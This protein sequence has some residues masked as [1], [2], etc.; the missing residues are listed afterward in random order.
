[1]RKVTHLISCAL[2]ACFL[3]APT[4]AGHAVA[5]AILPTS[6]APLA[7]S[8]YD[9]ASYG[10]SETAEKQAAA[11]WQGWQTG[12]LTAPL[13]SLQLT[14]FVKH[15]I[16][17]T[18]AAR[19]LALMHV[20]MHD[21]WLVK[22]DEVSRQLAVASAASQVLGYLF[23]SEEHDFERTLAALIKRSGSTSLAG[24]QVGRQIGQQAIARAEGDGAARGWNGLRLEWYGEGRYFGPGSW[25]PTP[26]YFYYPP[27]EPF[28]PSWRTW[29]VQDIAQLRTTAPAFGSEKFVRDLQEVL[30]VQK[31]LTPE[32]LRIAQFWVDGSGTVTPPGHWN[33]I[34]LDLA[35]EHRLSEADTVRLFASLN[36]A[37]ADTF[38]T[39]WDIKYHY[40]SARPVTMAKTVLGVEFTPA[41]LTPPFPSYVSG[42]AAFSGAA[43]KVIGAYI[44]A[45]AKKVE[46]MAEEAAM[47]RLY[48]G[49]HYRH[50]N[51][52]GLQVGRAV[53]QQ[54]L[55]KMIRRK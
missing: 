55:Q 3:A 20:A 47:S 9:P 38:I 4:F 22:Q 5:A 42:H 10:T 7:A 16:S 32:Q 8:N 48:G 37:L 1:M 19:G 17:P 13:T 41:I 40:W 28:A 25:E 23:V 35:R 21:A 6:A 24:V 14:M 54:V 44:P 18:R 50:D 12:T 33:Q 53:A 31:S 15:K 30:A 11:I 43:A 45:A 2:A 29:V 52:D 39:V 26:P 36:M 46:A 49:I 27:T 51:D 34:A